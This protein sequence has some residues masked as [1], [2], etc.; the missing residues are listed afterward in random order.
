MHKEKNPNLK[1][2]ESYIAPVDLFS[3][4]EVF[5]DTANLLQLDQN[6]NTF[7]NRL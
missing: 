2:V 1:I 6:Y 7:L 3:M 4:I 5:P